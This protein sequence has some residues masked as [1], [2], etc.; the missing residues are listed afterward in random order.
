MRML[1]KSFLTLAAATLLTVASCGLASADETA[2]AAGAATA[3]EPAG[4]A[5]PPSA[6][7]ET[8]TE[9]APDSATGT[10]EEPAY[11]PMPSEGP[12]G[13]CRHRAAQVPSA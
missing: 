7:D 4:E 12:G 5:A 8:Q 13:G 3:T 9:V 1:G 2:P 6:T 11:S 10:V